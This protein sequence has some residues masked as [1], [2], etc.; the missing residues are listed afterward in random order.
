M[1]KLKDLVPIKWVEWVFELNNSIWLLI[2]KWKTISSLNSNEIL[3]RKLSTFWNVSVPKSSRGMWEGARAFCV[4]NEIST[5]FFTNS[6]H[7]LVARVKNLDKTSTAFQLAQR[8]NLHSGHFSIPSKT[9]FWV[10]ISFHY[11]S[12]TRP[13][14][15][16]QQKERNP[17]WC[18][19]IYCVKFAF[20][21]M[22]FKHSNQKNGGREW[23]GRS[24][25]AS[26]KTFEHRRLSPSRLLGQF[27]FV[28]SLAYFYENQINQLV[29][30]KS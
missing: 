20:C 13:K 14:K 10:S 7:F 16:N 22:I 27:W 17:F 23:E 4:V 5:L 29:S 12:L 2:V 11:F 8:R 19:L 6:N 9:T 25:I 30:A 1:W 15:K 24:S 21:F 3:S 26:L 18:V 28:C